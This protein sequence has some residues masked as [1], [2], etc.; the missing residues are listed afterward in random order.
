MTSEHPN[1]TAYRRAADAFRSRD[2]A[3]LET[4]IADDVLWHVPG[5][6][7]MAGEVHGRDALMAWLGQLRSIGFWLTEQDVF[8]ND[9]HVCALSVMGARRDGVDVQ[10][11]VVS[12][13]RYRDGQQVE[14][15][16]HPEDP[17][18]WEEMFACLR[19]AIEIDWHTTEREDLR[20]LFELAEE[21]EVLD[22]Y[23]ELGRVLVALE[24]GVAVGHLQLVD[25]G[26]PATLEVKNMAVAETH[27]RRGIGRALVERAIAECRAE[28]AERWSSRPRRPTP[29]TCAST[30]GSASACCACSATPSPRRRATR[31][32]S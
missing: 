19:P 20:P 7:A 15:W 1:A 3:Q 8:G 31:M 17:V 11:R 10:T 18:V 27:H 26:L 24:G 32:A 22:S 12:V 4:L 28:G 21:P 5:A 16:I 25:P 30:S 14:R 9:D 2:L 23:L 29:A 13:F 6:H